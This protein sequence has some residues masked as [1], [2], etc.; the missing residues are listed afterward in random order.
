M[1]KKISVLL[2][3]IGIMASIA[4]CSKEEDKK[5][6]VKSDQVIPVEK[7]VDGEYE[8]NGKGFNGTT[9]V[10]VSV[11]NNEVNDIKVLSYEDDEEYMDSAKGIIKNMFDKKKIDVDEISGATYSSNGIKSAIND[12]L[13]KGK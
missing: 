11:K 10:K 13:A 12:A 3:S 9:K 2:L 8:G 1:N 4:G 5:E 7:T 6:E